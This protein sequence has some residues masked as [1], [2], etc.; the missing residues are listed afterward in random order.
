MRALT[1]TAQ[2]ALRPAVAANGVSVRIVALLAVGSFINYVDRGSLSTAA[3]LVRE[4]F[5]LSSTQLGLL[6]SAFFWS[7]APGQLP[8][9]WLAE[10][11][12]PRRVLACGLAIWGVATALAGLATGF[13]TL[14]MLRILLGCGESVMFPAS[15][16]IL[17]C[18]AAESQRGR[19]NGF[20]ASGLYLGS[21]F[22]TL[23]GALL[24][25]RLGW[26][27]VFIAAGC[28]SLLWLWPWWRT[29]QSPAAACRYTESRGRPSTLTLLRHREL[30]GSCL[31]A[32]CG[33]YAL[34]LVVTWLPL[35]LVKTRGFSMAQ[36][37]PIGATVYALSAGAA[38][39]TG[40]LSDRWL[41][42]GASGNRVRKTALL[43]AFGGLALCFSL[44]AYAGHVGSLVAL[45]GCGV[46]L[47]IKAAGL[48]NCVQTLGGPT[49]SARWMGVQNTCA[50]VAGITA[51]L[52]TGLVVDRTGSFT[53]AFM[54][55]ATLA[56]IGIVAF[57][58]VVRRIEPIDWSVTAGRGVAL[59]GA[60]TACQPEAA[61]PRRTAAQ[62]AVC[63]AKTC[64][65]QQKVLGFARVLRIRA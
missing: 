15:F 33:A 13:M 2:G 29:P 35:Y 11:L 60:A 48:Y 38:V 53:A 57:G 32:F 6:L 28:A 51:P 14:L 56:V 36:M 52:I 37:A 31:G 47:G 3:P 7:Y 9:G 22:G 1:S 39:L 25:A 27:I 5:A 20:L 26:R 43:V 61:T 46:C 42:R 50:N 55:A 12:D 4:E 21:A 41:A 8:A 24:M 18:E 16:K 58:F 30:W 23:V 45:G 10:R 62:D 17:A 64:R 65:D 49:A 44:C 63:V 19:A 59:P 34:Y 40:W 54:I